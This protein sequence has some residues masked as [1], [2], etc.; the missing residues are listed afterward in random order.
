MV[1]LWST[2]RNSLISKD[3]DQRVLDGDA[4][5]DVLVT[6][7]ELVV[8]V[9]RGGGEVVGPVGAMTA[10]TSMSIPKRRSSSCKMA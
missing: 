4:M 9:T 8:E 7:G 1:T 3:T 2:L 10:D 5:L 6:K